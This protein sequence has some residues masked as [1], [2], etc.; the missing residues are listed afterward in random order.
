RAPVPR[1]W[2]AA[3][4]G[5]R[6]LCPE[7][8][9]G[10]VVVLTCLALC[11]AALAQD[12]QRFAEA[13][14]QNQGA[15]RSYTW[16]SRTELKLKGETKNVKLEQVRYDLDGQLQKT[17]L[18]GAPQ[19]PQQQQGRG[20]RGRLKTKVVE[21]KKEEFA[22]LMQKLAHLVGSYGHMPPDR[23]QAFAEGATF[24]RGADALQG[25]IHIQ[26]ANV[27]QP[28]DALSVWIDP[29]TQMM[30]RVEIQTAL[31]GKPVTAVS[32]FRSVAG[33]PTYQARSVLQYPEKQVE[34]T[35]DNY[36]YQRGGQ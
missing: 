27:L 8:V 18:G 12:K 19:Q 33:G 26:G 28:G 7:G 13:Q 25:T 20:L 30:R 36:E 5:A 32:E 34:V 16:K 15:L 23:L 9:R 31:D 35:I 29:A 2:R 3:A 6:P 17:P 21:N 1:R 11:S 4:R 10:A 24:S 22:E 14:K